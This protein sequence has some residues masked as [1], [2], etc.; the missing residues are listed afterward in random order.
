ENARTIR[1]GATT[2]IA[3]LEKSPMA[4]SF[5]GGILQQ[6]CD[7]LADA[8]LKNQITVGGNVACRHPWAHLPPALMVLDAELVLL[9]KKKAVS[10][11]EFLKKKP[12]RKNVIA[13][14]RI[15]KEDNNGTGAFLKFSRTRND[16][17]RAIA[18]AFASLEDGKIKSL[19]V[20]V[21]GAVAPTRLRDLEK[22][23]VGQQP[24]ADAIKTAASEAVQKLGINKSIF[25]SEE[26]LRE[27]L[28]VL[29]RRAIAK[30]VGLD[31]GGV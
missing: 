12:V 30:V 26:Y 29:T 21:S 23:L 3:Q 22:A 27:V 19:R 2:T 25:F 9:G 5:C 6:T 16:Y 31:G 7:S 11:E 28:G 10:V 18:S 14:V 17:A 4:K 8:P 20:A 13:E 15:S 24:S 1:I